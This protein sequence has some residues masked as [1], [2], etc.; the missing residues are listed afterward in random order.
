MSYTKATS[1]SSTEGK[2]IDR[3]SYRGWMIR[4]SNPKIPCDAYLAQWLSDG[5]IVFGCGQFEKAESGLLHHQMYVVT[6][7]NPSN[8]NGYSMKW[9]KDNIH[10]T[11]HF[12]G[13]QGTHEQAVAYCTK[14]DTRQA[15]PWTVGEWSDVA[16]PTKGGEQNSS[17]ILAVKRKIDEGA[18]DA[19]LYETHFG[20]MLRYGKAFERYRVSMRSKHRTWQTKAVVL[21]GPPATGKSHKAWETAI[22]NYG[23]DDV[24]PLQLEGDTVWWDGYCG[25]KCVIIEEFYGQMKI[26][27]LLKLL[28]K[29][30][31]L[32]QTKG[33]MTPFIAEMIIFTTNEHPT[34]WYGKG[35]EPGLPSK[36]PLDVL[37]ALKRRFEGSLG[38]I[39]EMKDVFTGPDGQPD[40]SDLWSNMLTT[41]HTVR[42]ANETPV[43]SVDLTVDE[44]CEHS[45]H[46]VCELCAEGVEA[47]LCHECYNEP[48]TCGIMS[49]SPEPSQKR[50]IHIWCN[51]FSGDLPCDIVRRTDVDE[52]EWALTASSSTPPGVY[53]PTGPGKVQAKLGFKKPRPVNVDDD[54]DVDDKV[55]CRTKVTARWP[56]VSELPTDSRQEE[57]FPTG[58]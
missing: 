43:T 42:Q 31:L 39:Q 16:G 48:C 3:R 34:M 22:A 29:H 50:G 10:S 26:G 8:K 5:L 2:K 1:S 35:A 49:T 4:I 17:K 33:G 58:R 38:T 51:C 54:D 30:P 23:D 13:R 47:R 25:Q 18:H 44:G 37:R 32:V 19:E 56:P 11:A 55:V 52:R 15:G 41:A 24:Y 9:M 12:E 46:Y 36:I 20:E 40:V 21:F 6:K 14:E 45:D 28:D 53:K 27:Y 57:N 7:P